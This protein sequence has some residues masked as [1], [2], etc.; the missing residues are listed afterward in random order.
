MLVLAD[1]NI[2]IFSANPW[3]ILRNLCMM[4]SA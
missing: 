2:L 4:V 3:L 1:S